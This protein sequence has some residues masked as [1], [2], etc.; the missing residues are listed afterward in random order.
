LQKWFICHPERSE[1]SQIYENTRFFA[2]LRMTFKGKPYFATGYN[3]RQV[4][5]NHRKPTMTI[6]AS[7]R[8]L[9]PWLVAILLSVTVAFGLIEATRLW[10][11]QDYKEA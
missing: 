5:P 10:L 6:S 8:R 9:L 7:S 11:E 2:A 4:N 3:Y 1:G